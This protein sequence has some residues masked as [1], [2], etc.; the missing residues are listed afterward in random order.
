MSPEQASGEREL[1]GRTDI[2]SL[3]SVLYEMLAGRPPFTGPSAHSVIAQRMTSVPRP[4]RT[5]RTTVPPVLDAAVAKALERAPSDR[6]GTAAEFGAALAR[7]LPGAE[8][9]KRRRW[10]PCAR[11]ASDRRDA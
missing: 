7:S 1:D 6:F 4:V 9:P 8:E 3:A 10:W 11:S 2:Y 5:H